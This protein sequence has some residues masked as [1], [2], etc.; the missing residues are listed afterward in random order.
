MMQ[1][2]YVS[3]LEPDGSGYAN[4]GP[5]CLTMLLAHD[6]LVPATREAM[7]RVADY[8][9]DGYYDGDWWLGTYTDY[10][11]M[12]GLVEREYDRRTRVLTAWGDV[13][14]A[15]DAGRPVM[16]LLDN[17]PLEPRQ[18][19]RNAAWNAHH[20]IVVRGYGGGFFWVNDPLAY[21]VPGPGSYT[22][23]TVH[24]GVRRVGG[25]HALVIEEEVDMATIAEL[26]AKL[27]AVT[28]ERDNLRGVV[29]EYEKQIAYKDE[30][31][32]AAN[33]RAGINEELVRQRDA[34]IAQRDQE[35]TVFR[36]TVSDQDA[37]LA[38]LRSQG[39]VTFK[40]AKLVID[41]TTKTVEVPL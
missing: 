5:A 33:S 27:A 34:V 26:E 17:V 1:V 25:V 28:G 31:L 4:C 19:P 10:P 6:G 30:L 37:E 13:T 41:L 18:Y 9:R 3:Q 23:E 15:L 24:E 12:R 35:L 21:W 16:L 32:S 29:S 11:M 38:T 36:Q 14:A 22:D 39:A 2:P 40:G 20:F 8:V 7:H